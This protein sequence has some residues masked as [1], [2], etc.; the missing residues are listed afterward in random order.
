EP[1]KKRKNATGP[2]KDRTPDSIRLPGLRLL[3]LAES[4]ANALVVECEASNRD[5][6]NPFHFSAVALI[7]DTVRVADRLGIDCQP[8]LSAFENHLRKFKPRQS[9]NVRRMSFVA[10]E[11]D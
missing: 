5:R 7:L 8:I 6:L 1:L 9:G 3:T 4:V 11:K 2:V 10:R